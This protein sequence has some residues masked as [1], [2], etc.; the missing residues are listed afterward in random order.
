MSTPTPQIQIPVCQLMFRGSLDNKVA[1]KPM[2]YVASKRNCM[3]SSCRACTKKRCTCRSM[4]CTTRAALT[5]STG[6]NSS[7]APQSNA[8]KLPQSLNASSIRVAL[9]TNCCLIC[10]TPLAPCCCLG[11]DKQT[12]PYRRQVDRGDIA[13]IVTRLLLEKSQVLLGLF[14]IHLNGPAQGIE[15]EHF[16]GRA[17][18]LS[19]ETRTNHV[20]Q[21]APCRRQARP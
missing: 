16:G 5:P 12:K 9:P 1:G 14:E 7:R 13:G 3:G 10:A 6:V 21:A 19:S 15:F 18:D 20:C 8:P 4:V 17:G 11:L 2:I